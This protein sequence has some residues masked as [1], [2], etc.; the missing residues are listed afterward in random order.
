MKKIYLVILLIII[1]LTTLIVSVILIVNNNNDNKIE[2]LATQNSTISQNTI[3]INNS[4]SDNEVKL[5]AIQSSNNSPSIDNISISI[6]EGS[7]TPTGLTVIVDDKNE[8]KSN[9]LI[10]RDYYIDKKIG[11]EWKE[12]YC[13]SSPNDDA[14]ISI[15]YPKKSKLDWADGLGKLEQGTYKIRYYPFANKSKEIEF[16]IN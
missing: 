1:I 3:P 2:L 8:I 16:N 14:I 6:E 7:I 5:P 4:T 15:A 11:S 10:S 9:M 12:I 13:Y